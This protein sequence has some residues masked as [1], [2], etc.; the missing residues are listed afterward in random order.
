MTTPAH[1]AWCRSPRG[2]AP[3]LR[4]RSRSPG[5]LRIPLPHRERERAPGGRRP[6]GAPGAAH[7]GPQTWA[8]DLE[9]IETS[10]N[11]FGACTCEYASGF[12]T[13]RAGSA[14]VVGMCGSA[15]RI[16]R[17]WRCQL[18]SR[19]RTRGKIMARPF[20]SPR[21]TADPATWRTAWLGSIRV[22][23]LRM[24]NRALDG[25]GSVRCS[26]S[27]KALVWTRARL[28][29]A[30]AGCASIEAERPAGGDAD[31]I[32]SEQ[33][34]ASP[35]AIVG[36][37]FLRRPHPEPWALG[38]PLAGAWSRLAKREQESRI[39]APVGPVSVETRLRA[40][41]TGD[42]SRAGPPPY[43]FAPGAGGLHPATSSP[44]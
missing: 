19:P 11:I 35:I 41:V 34:I 15:P 25:C 43:P 8:W 6:S 20:P 18:C 26:P 32:K 4:K 14:R 16:K 39:S 3:S 44:G 13:W 21:R 40:L 23:P 7:R 28:Y 5:T 1:H 9:V 22:T 33:T 30:T 2:S 42:R 10:Q 37:V 27:W 12:G 17:T 29:D 38:G 36:A 31:K 24:Y